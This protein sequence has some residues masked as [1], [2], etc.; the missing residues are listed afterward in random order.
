MTIICICTFVPQIHM[1]AKR[2][3]CISNLSNLRREQH[4]EDQY[5]SGICFQIISV[6]DETYK[7]FP[8]NW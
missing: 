2:V 3:N 5:S 4:L 6:A 8:Y 1:M 7:L